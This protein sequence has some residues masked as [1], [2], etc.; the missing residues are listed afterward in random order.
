MYIWY[1]IS[2]ACVT[3][4]W[5]FDYT[6]SLRNTFSIP[7]IPKLIES[8][9]SCVCLTHAPLNGRPFNLHLIWMLRTL[10]KT[11][12]NPVFFLRLQCGRELTFHLE[13]NEIDYNYYYF[14]PNVV[15]FQ[16]FNWLIVVAWLLVRFRSISFLN[17]CFI[18]VIHIVF[19][20]FFFY[21]FFFSCRSPCVCVC[22][23]QN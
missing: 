10:R 23:W 22:Q 19:G 12:S 3:T 5:W 6:I 7:S 8:V 16:P 15:I 21:F 9:F 1:T 11:F 2:C 18:I 13:S 20:E 14:F 4:N 17:I